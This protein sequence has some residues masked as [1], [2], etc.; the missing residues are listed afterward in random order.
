[1]FRRASAE[2]D[3]SQGVQLRRSTAIRVAACAC[4][5]L[6]VA[7]LFGW[8]FEIGT[9][10]SIVPG[11]AGMKANTA[12]GLAL[13]SCA[14]W[15]LSFARASRGMLGAAWSAGGIVLALG[16]ATLAQYLLGI[17]LGIDELLVRDDVGAA[18][19]PSPGR[20][21]FNTASAF[22]LCGA[23]LLTARLHFR[24]AAACSQM[25]AALAF[26]IAFSAMLGYL[27]SFAAA[28]IT[29]LTPMALHTAAAFLVL[30][31]A[32]LM[33]TVDKGPVAAV[34]SDRHGGALARRLLPALII[35]IPVIGWI[36]LRAGYLEWQSAELNVAHYAAFNIL[37]LS[38]VI[39]ALAQWLN[40]AD[41]AQHVALERMN[42]SEQRF[43]NLTQNVPGVVYQRTLDAQG[44]VTYPFVS[45]A[46]RKVFGPDVDPARIMVDGSA[47][48]KT[49]HPDDLAR[50]VAARQKADREFSRLEVE[51][52]IITSDGE[53][54]WVQNVAQPRRQEDGSIIRDGLVIDIT[55]RKAAEARQATLEQ[56]LREAQKLEAVGQLTG[57]VAHDFNNLLTVIIGSNETLIE[58]L[59]PDQAGLKDLAER[60][61][62]A[63]LRASALT[64][65]LLAFSRRQILQ[66]MAFDL[67]VVVH[68]MG[69]M[70]RR[71]L[72]ETIEIET[73][74]ADGLWPVLADKPQVEAA[75]LN[76]A[77][78]ARDAM[79][80]GGTLA[81]A[82]ANV[83]LDDAYVASNVDVKAGPYVMLAVSDTGMGMVPEVIE[84][85]FEPF[86]TTKEA[87]KGTGLGLSMVF[88]FAKQSGGHVKIYSEIGHGTTVKLYLPRT[89]ALSTLAN[90][91]PAE[92][93]AGTGHG[94]R[95]LV[96]EDDAAVRAVAVGLLTGLGYKVVAVADGP[97]ALAEIDKGE[98]I[99]LL[100][101]D[102]VMPRGMTGRQLA[103]E[104]LRRRPGL[105]V[106]FTTG[107][108]RNSIGR[109]GRLEEGVELIVK[110]YRAADLAHRIAVM[111]APAVRAVS[112]P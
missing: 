100:F 46:I 88:G 42:E 60:T 29:S 53:I 62:Q 108:A 91:A 110:P 85:A 101:T 25:F 79:P 22:V 8:F 11:L 33:L 40:R 84:R 69:D 43:R 97:A 78:N 106:L 38:V 5:A 3:G 10:K 74:L 21:G 66:P 19:T 51:F 75:L 71:T 82:T 112:R 63:A 98:P 65:R 76:L 31:G 24:R 96:A 47:W 111:L 27:F 68:E 89:E 70:L 13:A 17:D 14:L 83:Q 73:V 1:M 87:G 28:T 12:S 6:S 90:E 72:G 61:N 9:L 56:Q 20:M 77:V 36:G 57:G 41:D 99:D 49:I 45:E 93:L 103:D 34:F 58:R 64:Q 54:R 44:R 55:E 15:L 86:F 2:T 102:I 7:V 50:F 67:N 39:V 80:D 81:I 18:A 35:L 92:D 32:I 30:A 109:D 107:Y 48:L 26:A 95:I 16:T 4:F 23:A 37:V 59:G 52:R 105:K 94:E 104:A